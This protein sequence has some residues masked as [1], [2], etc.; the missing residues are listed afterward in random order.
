VTIDELHAELV[1]T[2][3]RYE[4]QRTAER[5]SSRNEAPADL[6]PTL[7]EYRDPMNV[8]FSQAAWPL[9]KTWRDEMDAAL[10][11]T[12]KKFLEP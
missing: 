9:P 2:W 6:R 5:E 10:L 11:A 3:T 7:G 8:L 4:P 12:V 1:S